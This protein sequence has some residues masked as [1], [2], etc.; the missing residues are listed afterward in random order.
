[1]IITDGVD[2]LIPGG[3]VSFCYGDM[4]WTTGDASGGAGGFGGN[5]AT[6]GANLGDGSNYIQFG[7]FDS[8]GYAYDG[9]YNLNDG[10][11]WKNYQWCTPVII[12]V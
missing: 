7:R 11:D 5:A 2:P 9:P 10:V 4:Q 6:V 3:N 8:A 1:M 12:S